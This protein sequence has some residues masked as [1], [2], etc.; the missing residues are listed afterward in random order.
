MQTRTSRSTPLPENVLSL[1]V[2]RRAWNGVCVDI[3]EFHCA[4][5]VSHH[6]RHENET[7]LN[8]LLDETGTPCE[9]RFR[10]DQPCPISYM[11]RH[12]LF[13]PAGLEIWGYSADTRFV[14]D[15]T[16]TF[17]LAVLRERLGVEFDAAA[18]TTPR[19]R[20]SD[21]RI[22]PLARLLSGA[23]NDRDPSTQLYGDGLIAAIAAQLF[24]KSPEPG[25]ET[26]GL[27]PSRLRRVV[28]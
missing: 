11:P 6:L 14:R 22:W 28:E 8:I 1:S 7:R 20:F 16:L 5:R 12:M 9:P 3:S 13:A 23:V 21:D 19:L 17:D 26:K 25:A 27:A 15:A 10:K 24:A 18:T 2:A 4:G